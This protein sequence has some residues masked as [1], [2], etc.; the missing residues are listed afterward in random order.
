M[1]LQFALTNG[2]SPVL[3]RPTSQV[4]HR[5]EC[6]LTLWLFT[7]SENTKL[8]ISMYFLSPTADRPGTTNQRCMC[9]PINRSALHPIWINDTNKHLRS[10]NITLNPH[11]R[12]DNKPKC[13]ATIICQINKL[14][15]FPRLF[16][17]YPRLN[18]RG[19]HELPASCKLQSG[20]ITI[21]TVVM[22]WRQKIQNLT[23]K[24]SL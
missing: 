10:I 20:N 12:G 8:L 14:H 21:D 4:I 13:A 23:W 24:I 6:H 19:Q 7:Q 16:K 11:W 15:A 5:L 17:S 22:D 2:S 1:R 3:H 9:W 18:D